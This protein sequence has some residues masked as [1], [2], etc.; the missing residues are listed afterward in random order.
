MYLLEPMSAEPTSSLY[1]SA[2]QPLPSSSA[3]PQCTS[4]LGFGKTSFV[5]TA[6]RVSVFLVT[7]VLCWFNAG[8]SL[9][10]IPALSLRVFN[11]A[12]PRVAYKALQR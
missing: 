9:Q 8:D 3:S 1:E 11:V 6:V 5:N 12:C 4:R 10:A 7:L 2:D